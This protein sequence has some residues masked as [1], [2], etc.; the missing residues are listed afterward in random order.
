VQPLAPFAET[1]IRETLRQPLVQNLASRTASG[2]ANV[3]QGNLI[4]KARDQETTPT[5]QMLD[6]VTGAAF[7]KGQF[8]P[9]VN[10]KGQVDPDLFSK[11]INSIGMSIEPVEPKLIGYHLTSPET[12][13]KIREEGFKEAY[14]PEK[15]F[16]FVYAPGTDIPKQAR[17]NRQAVDID[18]TN[19]RLLPVEAGDVSKDL[20]RGYDGYLATVPPVRT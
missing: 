12:A 19:L 13:A 6:F 16:I 7:G 2:V 8:R 4:D 10:A 5:W 20:P 1:P 14:R 18:M 9:W 15:S 11:Y 3:M 17:A